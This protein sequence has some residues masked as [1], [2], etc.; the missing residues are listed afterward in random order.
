MTSF[1]ESSWRIDPCPASELG[2]LATLAATIWREW[3]PPLIGS[4]QVEYMLTKMYAVPQLAEDQRQGVTFLRL[5]RENSWGGFAGVGSPDA[6]GDAK[7]HKLYLQTSWHGSGGAAVLLRA[8][9]ENAYRQ[10]AP[11][12]ILAV[13]KNNVR[14]QA[15]YRKNGFEIYDSVVADIGGGF[16][17]DDFLLAK[18]LVSNVKNLT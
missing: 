7:L 17:M 13:N 5:W 2:A 18:R 1:P 11:R 3:Y 6:K 12:L 8:A 10:G 9:E 14:A 15:F 16:V 4:A